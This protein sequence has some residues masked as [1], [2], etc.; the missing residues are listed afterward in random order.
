MS[1]SFDFNLV[2]KASSENKASSTGNGSG[3]AALLTAPGDAEADG[4]GLPAVIELVLLPGS[5]AQATARVE[6]ANVS[7]SA[8]FLIVLILKYLILDYYS[9]RRFLLSLRCPSRAYCFAVLVA[10]LTLGEGD[11]AGEGLAT[12]LAVF[13]GAVVVGAVG[14]AD[15]DGAGLAVVGVVELFSGSVAQ[16]AAKAI[17]SV[18]T[19]S[20]AVRLIKFRFEDFISLTSLEQD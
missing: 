1:S 5:V 13:T 2:L 7:P 4:E 6:R 15:V 19:S 16:P 9:C 20:S 17:E 14:E 12:G 8:V 18:A 11:A 3:A 10:G